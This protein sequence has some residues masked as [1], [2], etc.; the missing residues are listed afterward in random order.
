MFFDLGVFTL[1]VGI[2]FPSFAVA[3]G[4]VFNIV[5]GCAV[6][7]SFSHSS[8]FLIFVSVSLNFFCGVCVMFLYWLFRLLPSFVMM[9]S[10]CC[11]ST[12]SV[13]VFVDK[14]LHSSSVI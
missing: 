3:C 11:L 10:Y 6:L 13:A 1:G 8:G 14:F 12:S 4:N 5:T 7:V 9:C 2:A